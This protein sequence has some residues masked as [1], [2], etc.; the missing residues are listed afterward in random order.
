M[1]IRTSVL[2][3]VCVIRVTGCAG[4][5]KDDGAKPESRSPRETT[6]PQDDGTFAPDPSDTLDDDLSPE[7][8]TEAPAPSPS[9]GSARGN[10]TEEQ[11]STPSPVADDPISPKPFT[12]PSTSIVTACSEATLRGADTSGARKLEKVE[13]LTALKDVI[14]TRHTYEELSR[15]QE[16]KDQSTKSFTNREPLQQAMNDFTPDVTDLPGEAFVST[17]SQEQLASWATVVDVVGQ[18]FAEKRWERDYDE[19]D[20]MEEQTPSEACYRGFVNALGRLAYRRPLDADETDRVV[21]LVTTAADRAEGVYRVVVRLFLAPQFMYVLEPGETQTAESGRVHLT[22]FEIAN[23]LSFAVTGR[24][25]DAAL[26]QAAA[27]GELTDS[28]IL[29]EHAARLV[30]TDAA[31][32]K[33]MRFFRD[34]VHIDRIPEPNLAWGNWAM[35]P[36]NGLYTAN[37]LDQHLRAEVEDYIR[38]IVWDE[39]GTYED[40]LTREI[41]MVKDERMQAVYE[42]TTF[43]ADGQPVDAPGYPGLF[44][45]AGLLASQGAATN[46]IRRAMN[47][48]AQALCQ[49]IPSP[50]FSVVA[51]RQDGVEQL[52]PLTTPNHAIVTGLTSPD[53]CHACHQYINPVGYLFEAYT[54]L[55]QRADKQFVVRNINDPVE[56]PRSYAIPS[57]P[58]GVKFAAIVTHDLP[59]PQSFTIED[60]LPTV[61]NSAEELLAAIA[62]SQSGPACLSVRFFRHLQ[63]RSETKSDACGINEGFASLRDKRILEGFVDSIVNEDIFWRQQ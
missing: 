23:R 26:A 1:T 63:R 10:E 39:E 7:F 52:D 61:Y 53:A 3:L 22:Q 62:V 43:H 31:K 28:T 50:D 56:W 46:P 21:R 29:R 4:T 45:R 35:I 55:G 34:W 41:A 19:N 60:G 54:P 6:T 20:C 15:L 5:V 18:R 51:A 25:P 42:T 2:A 49:T 11:P 59:G 47:V 58:S 8:E 13:L 44:T 32:E 17:F 14:A 48:K 27:D 30:R 57:L 33:L 12:P 9:T 38:Y 37:R 40:L 16:Y 24:A 36:D